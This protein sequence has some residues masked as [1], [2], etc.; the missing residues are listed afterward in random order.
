MT[1]PEP[2][3]RAGGCRPP[4]LAEAEAAE[5]IVE[6]VVGR[7]FRLLAADRAGAGNRAHVDDRG[8]EGLDERGEIRQRA[9]DRR[10]AG[11]RDRWRRG[12]VGPR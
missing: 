1:K 7:N 9:G 2:S 10:L 11:R 12:L 3:P 4:R 8:A 5:E 6:R